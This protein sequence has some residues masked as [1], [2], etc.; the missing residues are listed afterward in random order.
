[1]PRISE[2]YG[3]VI[4]MYWFDTDRHKLPHFHVRYQ[5]Q[6]WVYG[7]D[8]NLLGGPK[9]CPGSQSDQSMV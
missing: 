2:F 9:K 8:G 3:L 4:Y 1:M 7:F 6:E 5:G